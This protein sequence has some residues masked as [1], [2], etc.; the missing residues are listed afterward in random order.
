MAG[1]TRNTA[2]KTEVSHQ[3]TALS[4]KHYSAV[5]VKT[6]MSAALGTSTIEANP[7][8]ILEKAAVRLSRTGLS[9]TTHVITTRTKNN[10]FLTRSQ[11]AQITLM[12]SRTITQ[13][14]AQY[15]TL[16]LTFTV[17][18]AVKSTRLNSITHANSLK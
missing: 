16:H 12:C 10:N 9:R 8:I 6:N 15:V 5:A 7:A 4:S 1:S 13:K 18:Q 3:E 17:Y 11:Q 14:K 2:R